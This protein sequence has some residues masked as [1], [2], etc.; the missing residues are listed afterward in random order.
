MAEGALVQDL[1]VRARTRQPGGD[2]RLPV[3][4]DPFSSRRIQPFGQRREHHGDLPGRGFQTVQGSVALCTERGVAGLTTKRLDPFGLAMLAIANK[5][6]HVSIGNA[7]VGALVVG[8]GETLCVHP[9]GRSP[10]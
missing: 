5:S 1:C 8:T 4:E 2:S 10:A 7:E 3:A 6:M 9:L